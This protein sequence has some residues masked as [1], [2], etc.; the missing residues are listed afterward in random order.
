MNR[1]IHKKWNLNDLFEIVVSMLIASFLISPILGIP[2]G[3]LIYFLLFNPINE[4]KE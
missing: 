1:L 4:I 2:T 3:I